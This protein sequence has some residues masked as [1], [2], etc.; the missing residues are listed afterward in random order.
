[1]NG[2]VILAA[3]SGSRM[4]LGYNKMIHQIDG[5]YII[6]ITLKKFLAIDSF[7]PI[8]V[9][10]SENDYDFIN[11]ILIKDSKVTIVKGGAERQD[12][13]CNGVVHLK[14]NH[15]LNYIFIHDG[16]RCNISNKLLKKCIDEVA[17]E[18]FDAYAVGVYEKN[19]IRVVEDGIVKQIL[20]RDHLMAMQ[21][22]Q[23]AKADLLY[24]VLTTSK[25][26]HSDEVGL[27]FEN[28]YE[29][30]IIEGEYGNVKI[31][32]IEDLKGVK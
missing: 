16:A 8:V 7:G 32:T 15:D 27:L 23:I 31:T 5:E 24:E 19:S 13:V 3:G 25:N 14:K 17:L 12:S 30:S 2:V 20:N 26:Y 9:V 1:M 18:K 22:P 10:V 6:N 11:D 21:T 4:N 29:I 28:G